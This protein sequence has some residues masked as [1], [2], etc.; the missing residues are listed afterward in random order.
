MGQDSPLHRANVL[1]PAVIGDAVGAAG[2]IAAS[3]GGD[4]NR[5]LDETFYLLGSAL[6]STSMRP[7][8]QS[9]PP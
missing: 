2:D 5:L 9:R 6:A 8:K 4:P 3:R 7:Q 1:G